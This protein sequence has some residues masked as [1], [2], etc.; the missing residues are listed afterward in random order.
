MVR[1]TKGSSRARALRLLGV[2]VVASMA[3][4]ACGGSSGTSSSSG[5]KDTKI[6]VSLITKDSTNPFFVAMQSGAKKAAKDLG[7]DI[8]IASGKA[9]GD[10]QGQ[11][12]ATKVQLAYCRITRADLALDLVAIFSVGIDVSNARILL[13]SSQVIFRL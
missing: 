5:S 6:A 13:V 12:D 8:T 11:I 9:E 2:G 7:I 4:V 1:W 10:D 3:L